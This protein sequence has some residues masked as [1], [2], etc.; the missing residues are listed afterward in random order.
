MFFDPSESRPRRVGVLVAGRCRER[1]FV[2]CNGFPKRLLV[3]PEPRG[4]DGDAVDEVDLR[5]GVPGFDR[6]SDPTRELLSFAGLRVGVEGFTPGLRAVPAAVAVDRFRPT[7]EPI[8]GFAPPVAALR[9]PPDNA[10][11]RFARVEVRD[12]SFDRDDSPEARPDEL[13]VLRVSARRCWE[14]VNGHVSVPFVF[15]LR[16]RI[17][18]ECSSVPLR[19][20]RIRWTV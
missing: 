9:E 18:S 4:R 6:A 5:A 15:V 10:A 16:G 20:L 14:P 11:E 17:S 3:P 1:L 7:T 13:F 8:P 12:G 2:N 19:G